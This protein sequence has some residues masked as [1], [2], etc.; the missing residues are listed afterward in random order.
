MMRRRWLVT[1]AGLVVAGTCGPL[2]CSSGD[3]GNSGFSNGGGGGSTSSGGSNGG[4]SNG[5]GSNG[6]GSGGASSSG[7]GGGAS[8]NGGASSGGAS[9]S[10]SGNGS[11]GAGSSGAGSS[12][13]S[14]SGSGSGSGGSGGS[15]GGSSGASSSG[16]SSGSSGGG[17][18]SSSGG[19]DGGGSSGSGGSSSGGSSGS[20]SGVDAGPNA[21]ST[22]TRPQ[23][24]DTQAA[25]D[26]IL[27]YL[28][29]AGTIGSLVTDNW[30]P[31]AG[32]GNASGFTPNFTVAADGSGTHTTVQA[33]L[34]AA[35]GSSRVYILVKP[36]TYREVVC[37]KSGSPPITLYSTNTDATQTTIVFNNEAASI[38]TANPCS[39]STTGTFATA[40]VMVNANAF[41]AKN[42]TMS[43]DFAPTSGTAQ[44]VAL[45]TMADQIVLENVRLHGYQDTFFMHTT[46]TTTVQRVYV[47]NSFIEG[48]TDFIFGRATAV[49]D[50]CTINY[51]SNRKQGGTIV[52]PSTDPNNNYG[53]LVFGSNLISDSGTTASSVYLG[54][55]W[56]NGVASASAYVPGTSPNGQALIS[57]SALAIDIRMGSPWAAAATSSRPFA[58]T[59]ANANRLY[60]YRNSGPG[61]AP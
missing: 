48:D 28:A 14:T 55:A 30:N 4:G 56:D 33:A 27:K 11:S 20:S 40:T 31:T 9:S 50:G 23:L 18:T 29:Q 6:G 57:E 34:N 13:G 10:G 16:A 12:G 8:S 44:A 38:G 45:M 47:K 35:T 22:A 60:E 54:R 32:L 61:A 3:Q 24:T 26:T 21:T 2:A 52:A 58:S 17:S 42:L 39:T 46:A 53:F 5:G 25:S 59:G 41:Q 51:L 19:A 43:N 15:S 1:V 37:V 7:S 36:G 49:L